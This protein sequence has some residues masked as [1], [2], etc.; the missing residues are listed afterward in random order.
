MPNVFIEGYGCSLNKSDTLQIQGFLESHGFSFSALE[1]ADFAIIN[2][3]AV[4]QATEFKMLKRIRGLFALS[5]KFCFKLVVFGC[6]PAINAKEIQKISPSIVQIGPS[7]EQLAEFFSLEKKEFSPGIPDAKCKSLVSILPICR[8]CLGECNFCAVRRARGSLKSYSLA[9]LNKKFSELLARSKEI[10]LTAQDT[11]CYGR[12]IG[13]SLFELLRLLLENK[14]NFRVR[15]GMMNPTHL[16]E[17]LPKIIE[18]LKD[19]RLY[20][21]LHVPFQSGSNKILRAMNRKYAIEDFVSSIKKLRKEF[22]DISLSTDIIAGFPGETEK[23]F[24]KTLS[25]LKKLDFDVVNISRYGKRPFTPAAKMPKQIFEWEKKRRSRIASKLCR[26]ISLARN[27][28]LLGRTLEL[29]VNET[30]KGNSFVG[31]SQNYKPVA[32]KQNFL[33]KFAKA[34]II[35]A[36]PTYLAGKALN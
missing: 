2:T 27:K 20:L 34:K 1:K 26:E 33:G 5:K 22:P 24:E 35:G 7:L 16:K 29:F 28:R 17:L 18:L 3:C 14:G 13:T 4:K 8:G 21:F 12:D 30:G 32:I 23:D 36:F 15:I 10:W 25:V 6:L 11:G 31:R 19:K 9:S